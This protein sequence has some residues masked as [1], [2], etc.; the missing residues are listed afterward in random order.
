MHRDDWCFFLDFDGTLVELVAHPDAVEVN[1]QLRELLLRLHTRAAG[2]LAI[3]SGRSLRDIDRHLGL[4]QFVAAGTHGLEIRNSAGGVTE[5][6]G[7][8][9]DSAAIGA[10]MRALAAR[11]PTLMLEDKGR[12]FALH[13]RA[14]PELA[15]MC[16]TEVAKIVAAHPEY[17]VQRG[18]MV[19]EVK[20]A[21]VDKGVAVQYLM[22]DAV[23]R[24]R[25]PIFLGD[26][27]TDE[28]G[29]RV[30]QASGGF[31][32]KIGSGPSCARY[33]IADVAGVHR[34]LAKIA[35]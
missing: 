1:Q 31:A 11:A 16:E 2:A 30:A 7:V 3:V 10:G 15:S 26:D 32:V 17:A 6:D 20:P 12:S 14:G 21:H 28:H 27:L 4:P 23:F 18:K 22:R 19:I 25:K 5:P 13:Y 24:A 29:F 33:G 35:A 34:W 8:A 9:A